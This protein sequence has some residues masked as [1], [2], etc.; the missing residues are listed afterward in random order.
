LPYYL[1]NDYRT[2]NCT[3]KKRKKKKQV[4]Q[5]KKKTKK[6][7]KRKEKAP[8]RKSKAIT[9]FPLKRGFARSKLRCS[10]Y[11]RLQNVMGASILKH[12]LNLLYK[13][14]EGHPFPNTLPYLCSVY[15]KITSMKIRLALHLW[16]IPLCQISC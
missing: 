5:V 14:E 4:K 12:S 6:K 16:L 2:L 15:C 8:P 7:E 9:T 10:K 11:L 3:Q 13:K 1:I